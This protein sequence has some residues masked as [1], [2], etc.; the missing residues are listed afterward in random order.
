MALPRLSLL[1]VLTLAY[2]L[3]PFGTA[4][5]DYLTDYTQT[6]DQATVG[7]VFDTY[8]Q[9]APGGSTLETDYN[10]LFVGDEEAASTQSMLP[11]T[12]YGRQGVANALASGTDSAL[13]SRM[14][15]LREGGRLAPQRVAVAARTA[16]FT[17]LQPSNESLHDL[18]V[19]AETTAEGST[20]AHYPLYSPAVYEEPIPDKPADTWV[21]RRYDSL[22]RDIGIGAGAANATT[23]DIDRPRQRIVLNKADRAGRATVDWAGEVGGAPPAFT[24]GKD[25][26]PRHTLATLSERTGALRRAAPYPGQPLSALGGGAPHSAAPVGAVAPPVIYG[27]GE[28]PASFAPAQIAAPAVPVRT[29][30]APASSAP[31]LYKEIDQSDTLTTPPAGLKASTSLNLRQSRH[32]AMTSATEG[33][34]ADDALK[35]KLNIP[36][37]EPSDAGVLLWTSDESWGPSD[38]R[39]AAPAKEQGSL[40]AATIATIEDAQ[41]P[42][43][44]TETKAM[45]QPSPT[46]AALPPAPRS[47]AVPL[48]GPVSAD[49]RLGFFITGTTGYGHDD[50]QKDSASAK[51]TRAGFTVGGDYRV[52]G[53]SFVGMALTYAHNSFT[54]GSLGDLKADSVA[55][56][57]Y[58]TT[59]YAQNAYVDG[60]ISLGLHSLDSKRTVLAGAGTTRGAKATS[61]GLQFTGKAETGYDIADGALKYGPYAGMRLSYADFDGYTESGA[62]N[63]DLSVGGED[64]LSA[65]GSLGLGGSWVATMGDTGVLLPA[66]RIGYNHEFGDDRATV[67]ASFVN[68]AGSSFTTKGAKKARDWVNV[69]PSITAALTNDWAFSAQY[70]HDFFRDDSAENVFN[71]GARYVW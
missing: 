33:E 67:K 47:V 26:M 71:L 16:P 39:D 17:D 21:E 43:G 29:Q 28:E 37:R 25:G 13:S 38:A 46:A 41:K 1:P 53:Q 23:R 10:R 60:Y 61:D 48:A 63:F 11:T 30:P 19:K 68:L 40:P 12:A 3:V 35:K 34:G 24:D 22:M 70:E 55:L 31:S 49:R 44:E 69:T 27:L 18:R 42:E 15:A 59:D 5:A 57:L 14:R 20:S 9:A 4:R 58:G 62:G 54:T 50:L 6:P 64:S 32:F 65:V 52:T 7:G 36:P 45:P 56:S 2:A 66:L 51:A 8:G